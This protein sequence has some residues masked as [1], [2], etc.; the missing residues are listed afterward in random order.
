MVEVQSCSLGTNWSKSVWL[1]ANCKSFSA[2]STMS[3]FQESLKTTSQEG[4]ELSVDLM[5][6]VS[7]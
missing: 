2:S 3:L 4:P 5:D 1:V 6:M 7:L